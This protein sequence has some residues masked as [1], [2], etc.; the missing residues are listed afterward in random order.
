[1]NDTTRIL[2][3]EDNIPDFELAKREISRSLKNCEFKRVQTRREYLKALDAFQPDII[4]SDY[5]L[6]GF[7]GMKALHLAHEHA[8]LTPLIIWTGTTREDIAVDCMKAG[9]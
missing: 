2:I 6:P 9:A 5:T 3:V 7:N 8:P 1:M 4:L